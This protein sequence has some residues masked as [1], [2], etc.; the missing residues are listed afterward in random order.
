MSE[1]PL[2][3][4]ALEHACLKAA[5]ELNRETKGAVKVVEVY[6]NMLAL[7]RGTPP[8]RSCEGNHPKT[9]A[10]T[11]FEGG[12]TLEGNQQISEVSKA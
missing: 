3:R 7:F 8:G 12:R 6:H 5:V 11:G 9:P 1:T 10:T 4:A 2:E